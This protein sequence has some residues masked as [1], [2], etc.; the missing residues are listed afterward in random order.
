MKIG[1]IY[2]PVRTL[3]YGDRVG[4]WTTGCLLNCTNCISP[5]LQNINAGVELTVDYILDII[6]NTDKIVDGVTISGGE[7]FL[8]KQELL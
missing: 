7:P 5:E 6:L 8:Q 2:F 4:I 3:G 1:R